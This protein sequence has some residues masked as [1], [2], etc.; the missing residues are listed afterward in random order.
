MEPIGCPETSV[1]DY[2]TALRDIA[3]EL[4]SHLHLCGILK[5]RIINTSLCLK[6]KFLR[7]TK[8]RAE[9]SRI[10]DSIPFKSVVSCAQHSRRICGR[11]WALFIPLAPNDVYICPT[12]QLTSRRCISNIYS[13]NI[14]TE[15]F[16]HAA[17]SQ[18]FSL[19][20]AVYFIMLSFSVPAIFT[21]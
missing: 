13:T 17:H 18:F 9:R 8:L 11:R 16:K 21:F 15:Y 2:H 4:K 14:L 5:S 20:D 6:V 10:P 19:Q 12:A 3:K 7:F 1:S